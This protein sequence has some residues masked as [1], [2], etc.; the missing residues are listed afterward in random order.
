M[1]AVVFDLGLLGEALARN[2]PLL[3][4]SFREDYPE[5]KI[6]GPEWVKVRSLLSGI[7]GSD[8][9]LIT[10]SESMYLSPLVSFPAVLGH[11]VV[12]VVEEVGEGV[13]GV[14]EGDRV[15]LDNVLSCRVRGLD[16]CPSCREG[17]YSLCYN[18][19]RGILSPGMFTGV[20]K[21][22][23]GGWGEYFVAHEFQLFK[24]PSEVR[25]ED[26]V[27]HRALCCFPPRGT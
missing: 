23:G 25:D 5:P 18:F 1:K 22:T 6:L 8:I 26:A 12:G 21:D 3:L 16:P 15:V 2:D 4:V 19:D 14:A 11:E 9:R 27:F 17:R 7:C 10:L 20:C 13:R 24:V